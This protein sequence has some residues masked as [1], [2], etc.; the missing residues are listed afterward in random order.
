MTPS[1]GSLPRSQQPRS[2]SPA[3]RSAEFAETQRRL[4]H[5]AAERRLEATKRA[6]PRHPPSRSRTAK[7]RGPA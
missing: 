7:T 4:K 1:E 3:E 6:A 2:A 5:E